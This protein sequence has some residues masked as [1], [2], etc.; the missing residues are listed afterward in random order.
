MLKKCVVMQNNIPVPPL[1]DGKE[2]TINYERR[3]NDYFAKLN[4]LKYDIILEFLN[5]Y[6]SKSNLNY[7]KLKDFKNIDESIFLDNEY[8]EI[9]FNKYSDQLNKNLNISKSDIIYQDNNI[10]FIIYIQKILSKINYAM[11][12]KKNGKYSIYYPNNN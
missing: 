3:V 2:S 5:I 9:L 6:V 12:K 4:G 8:N 10:N 1:Y 11:I 7:N